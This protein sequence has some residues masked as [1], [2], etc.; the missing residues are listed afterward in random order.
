M[1][2]TDCQK[3]VYNM[4]TWKRETYEGPEGKELPVLRHGKSPNCEECPRGGPK[5]EE[6]TKL[7]LKN[8]KAFDYYERAKATPGFR[9]PEHLVRCR[10]FQTN[11]AII[12]DVL[13]EVEKSE[14]REQFE[15]LALNVGR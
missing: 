10:I 1:S 13:S 3:Y 11:C 9:V 14:R 7:S 4:D 8:K 2:C 12:A 15:L 5:N 6:S